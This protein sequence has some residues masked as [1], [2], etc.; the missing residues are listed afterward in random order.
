L[1]HSTQSYNVFIVNKYV[2][3]LSEVPP[4]LEDKLKFPDA[5][6]LKVFDGML[7][8]GEQ[9]QE[10]AWQKYCQF[11]SRREGK[12]RIRIKAGCEFKLI[13]QMIEDGTLPFMPKPVAPEDLRP[14]SDSG[15]VKYA[16]LCKSKNIAELQDRAW[17][18]FLQHGAIG[19]YW[20]FG[21]GK[22]LFGHRIIGSLKGPHLVVVPSIILKEQWLERL[23]VFNPQAKTEVTVETY[24]A[25]DKVAKKQWNTV[26]WDESQHLPATTFIKLS[27]IQAKYRLGFSVS[28][29]TIIPL[30]KGEDVR[31]VRI[32]DFATGFLGDTVGIVSVEG[33]ETVGVKSDGTVDWTPITEVHRYKLS[34]PKKLLEVCLSNGRSVKVTSDHSLMIWDTENLC[35]NSKKSSEL[36]AGDFLVVPKKLP[37]TQSVR[38][39]DALSLLKEDDIMVKVESLPTGFNKL[40]LSASSCGSSPNDRYNWKKRMSFPAHI[41]TSISSPEE[42]AC[43]KTIYVHKQNCGINV[44]LNAEK[45]AFVLGV[46]MGDGWIDKNRISFALS[47]GAQADQLIAQVQALG[48]ITVK[49]EKWRNYVLVK[50]ESEAIVLLFEKLGLHNG[51]TTKEIPSWILGHQNFYQPFL[52]GLFLADGYHQ[53]GSSNRE[54]LIISTS[55]YGL[56]RGVEFLY[57]ALGHISGTSRRTASPHLLRGSMIRP[58]ATNELVRINP[59]GEK[60]LTYLPFTGKLLEVYESLSKIRG[61][62][63][64]F[65]I[66]NGLKKRKRLSFQTAKTLLQRAGLENEWIDS[67]DIGFVEVKSVTELQEEPYVY[68]LTTGTESFL[69][70]GIF[71]HNSGSPFREDGR[72]NYIFALTGFPIGMSWAE[73]LKLRILNVPQFRVYVLPD[74]KSKDRKLG[75]LMRLP[76]KTIV[77]C[78][79]LDYGEE[80]SKRFEIPFVYGE[81]TERLDIIR[82]S[83]AC[84]VSRVGDEGLSDLKLER[85]IEVSYLFGSRQ[86]ESQRFGRL[87]HSERKTQHIILMTRA[88]YD[89]YQKRLLAITQRGF[90]LELIEEAA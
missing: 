48:V 72:E 61:K 36:Q 3:W 84:V 33:L 13:A 38:E 27:T 31:L 77:F 87:M 66:I 62:P 28:G 74:R 19:L 50:V 51:A 35:V 45:L 16:E 43:V 46:F 79:S 53:T 34:Q 6:P 78:D 47:D 14:W 44:K 88:E 85:V 11:L 64:P 86:Q 32:A 10:R 80:I 22:S 90:K 2:K 70:N 68:D 81:T 1:D 89:A 29:D 12:D 69:G 25:Y 26:I 37:Q 60:R 40:Y 21:T 54:T 8:T 20:S 52:D 76:L 39:V 17:N 42:Q 41:F 58:T 82:S 5:L 57:A 4:E 71:C 55:S 56:A 49:K 18:E 24:H 7:L 9:L 30:R 15:S 65:P 75:E 63:T 73:L 23:S 67:L 59:K 83:Q